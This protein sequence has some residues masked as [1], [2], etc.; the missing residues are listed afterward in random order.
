MTQLRPIVQNTPWKPESD[1]WNEL[2][3]RASRDQLAGG[4]YFDS[5]GNFV[6][7]LFKGPPAV[8]FAPGATVPAYGVFVATA[9][10]NRN[11]YWVY[12]GNQATVHGGGS[13]VLVNGCDDA[14][15]G[16]IG[17][18]GEAR[19]VPVW[20]L[21]DTADGTPQPG[22]SC[23]PKADLWYLGR[24]LPGFVVLA[25][26][27]ANGRALVSRTQGD[28]TRTARLST[29]LG[30]GSG[31]AAL[32]YEGEATGLSVQVS[33]DMLGAGDTIAANTMITV[34]FWPHASAWK[35]VNAACPAGS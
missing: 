33:D 1:Q 13:I 18:A 9:A 21:Y 19:E 25:V 4:G 5:L 22:E 14:S 24:G 20:A 31:M 28:N 30:P 27:G 23:G 32:W 12:N 10:N 29:P 3:A 6:R 26:D 17:W 15:S 11:D 35:V 7:R 16:A 8:P 2:I 34:Q